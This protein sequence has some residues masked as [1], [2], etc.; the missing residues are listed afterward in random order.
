M[1]RVKFRR[2]AL[3]IAAALFLALLTDRV[4]LYAWGV[5]VRGFYRSLHQYVESSGTNTS[6]GISIGDVKWYELPIGEDENGPLS[7][8]F[9]N[10]S[11]RPDY[12]QRDRYGFT[13]WYFPPR[14]AWTTRLLPVYSGDESPRPRSF[15]PVHYYAYRLSF[16]GSG[17]WSKAVV[18]LSRPGVDD[19]PIPVTARCPEIF[20]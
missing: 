16:H 4:A 11:V 3:G 7:V 9:M 10:S 18:E 12:I 15:S 8:P 2:V 13:L 14:L 20:P 6:P 5:G 19:R 1:Q 17:K